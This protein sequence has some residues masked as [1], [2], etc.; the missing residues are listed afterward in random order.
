MP[1]LKK[2]VEKTYQKPQRAETPLIQLKSTSHNLQGDPM[3]TFTG[4]ENT[5]KEKTV[6]SGDHSA[7]D[8]WKLKQK[9]W[10]ILRVEK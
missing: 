5:T 9:I 4:F 2:T 10:W 6:A 1:V 3:Y 8:T 7:Y